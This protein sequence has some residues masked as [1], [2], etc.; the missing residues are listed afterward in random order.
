MGLK[1]CDLQSTI[2]RRSPFG[3]IRKGTAFSD[4]GAEAILRMRRV[5]LQNPLHVVH[6]PALSGPTQLFAVQHKG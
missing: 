1:T 4:S 6:T 5:M 3:G 2:A